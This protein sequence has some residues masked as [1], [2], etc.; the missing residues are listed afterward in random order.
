MIGSREIKKLKKE[1]T[2]ARPAP[3]KKR[4]LDALGFIFVFVF[5]NE[6]LLF[7]LARFVIGKLRFSDSVIWRI[8]WC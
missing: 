2:P 4:C 7:S 8:I 5:V 3:T 6:S 1:T